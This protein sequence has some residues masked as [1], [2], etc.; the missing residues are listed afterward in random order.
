MSPGTCRLW[1][2]V[3]SCKGRA[4]RLRNQLPGDGAHVSRVPGALTPHVAGLSASPASRSADGVGERLRGHRHADPPLG[5][6]RPA[7][8]PLLA[9][10]GLQPL[11]HLRGTSRAPARP[12][13]GGPG[14][15]GRRARPGQTLGRCPCKP[16]G[17]LPSPAVSRPSRQL[18][19][20]NSARNGVV[21]IFKFYESK[22]GQKAPKKGPHWV[23]CFQE[24]APVDLNS[25][26]PTCTRLPL[27][28]G[29]CVR[30]THS[31]F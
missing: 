9:R 6:R 2:R 20:R 5:E 29:L 15:C 4:H 28:S 1:A 19:H 16:P 27:L 11:P 22:F 21:S 10:R 30:S 3:L 8:L 31:A 17:G 25:S 12:W 13:A 26:G 14:S 24:D 7:V 18:C 23:V